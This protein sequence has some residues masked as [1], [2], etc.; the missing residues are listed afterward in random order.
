[1]NNF[2]IVIKKFDE[3]WEQF[4]PALKPRQLR[5]PKLKR[6]KELFFKELSKILIKYHLTESE[7]CDYLYWK[8]R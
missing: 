1:M 6:Q 5:N 4:F 2:K 8:C 3:L 7:F